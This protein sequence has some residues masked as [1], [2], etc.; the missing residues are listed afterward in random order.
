MELITFSLKR[1]SLCPNNPYSVPGCHQVLPLKACHVSQLHHLP[2]TKL[3]PSPRPMQPY[4]SSSSHTHCWPQIHW[5]R[6]MLGLQSSTS[7]F[8]HIK[9]LAAPNVNC[10]FMALPL[11]ECPSAH[12]LHPH[13]C[14][15]FTMS[16]KISLTI[17]S[18]DNVIPASSHPSNP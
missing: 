8:G 10:N 11:L 18:Y 15:C 17:L 16:R 9:H 4:L 5:N 14:W 2:Y 3:L 13:P 1:V 6:N 12:L 7:G